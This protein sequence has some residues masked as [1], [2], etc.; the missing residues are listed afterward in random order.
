MRRSILPVVALVALLP[1]AACGDDDDAPS[2]P[3]AVKTGTTEVRAE[4]VPAPDDTGM[5]G[6]GVE[7]DLT[8]GS[9]PAPATELR[10]PGVSAVGT[11]G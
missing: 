3:T 5:R 9:A 2:S 10:G 8:T 4:P 1:L 7:T 11:G 6:D